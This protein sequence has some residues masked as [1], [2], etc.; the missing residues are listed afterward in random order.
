VERLKSFQQ[1]YTHKEL[2]N[3]TNFIGTFNSMHRYYYDYYDPLYL[4][5]YLI[6]IGEVDYE[7]KSK[8]E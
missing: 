1:E 5:K 4:L 6:I 7:D 8:N 3:N 2:F